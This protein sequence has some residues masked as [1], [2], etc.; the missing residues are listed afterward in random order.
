MI[1]FS[2]TQTVNG[3]LCYN[4]HMEDAM[5]LRSSARTNEEIKNCMVSIAASDQDWFATVLMSDRFNMETV[6]NIFCTSGKDLVQFNSTCDVVR[7]DVA[8]TYPGGKISHC[9]GEQFL[10]GGIRQLIPHFLPV[11][12]NSVPNLQEGF[13]IIHGIARADLS[14]WQLIGRWNMMYDACIETDEVIP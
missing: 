13:D 5:E 4:Y 9:V 3:Q 2:Q 11:D 7:N 14:K 10:L 8:A 1:F 12:W 6:S